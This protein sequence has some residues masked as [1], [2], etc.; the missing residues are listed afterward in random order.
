MSKKKMFYVRFGRQFDFLDETPSSQRDLPQLFGTYM[1]G[2]E[3]TK[4]IDG[5][6][7]TVVELQDGT[8]ELR[9]NLALMPDRRAKERPPSPLPEYGTWWPPSGT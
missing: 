9:D 7:V 5:Q 8:E 1:T 3:K 4:V 2:V 6:E